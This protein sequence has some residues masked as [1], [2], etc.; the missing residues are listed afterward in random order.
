MVLSLSESAICFSSLRIWRQIAACVGA[1][2]LPQLSP[3]TCWQ[4]LGATDGTNGGCRAGCYRLSC[5][6]RRTAAA[7]KR[8]RSDPSTHLA[9]SVGVAPLVAKLRALRALVIFVVVLVAATELAV[10]L[11]KPNG[12]GRVGGGQRAGNGNQVAAMRT[13]SPWLFRTGLRLKRDKLVGMVIC[14][15]YSKV[16]CG[17][18]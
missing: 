6:G 15:R 10:N 5:S 16:K 18:H 1:F 7:P 2:S 11:R 14:L 8:P 4:E 12:A 9:V 17:P 13:V 3:S